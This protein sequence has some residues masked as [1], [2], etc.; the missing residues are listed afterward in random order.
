M[1]I[2]H[3]SI[4]LYHKKHLES[5]TCAMRKE[6]MEKK[7]TGYKHETIWNSPTNCTQYRKGQDMSINWSITNIHVQGR[8]MF[9]RQSDGS[10]MIV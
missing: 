7:E 3:R 4:H 9:I 5:N 8:N 2:L 1:T 6:L 10:I